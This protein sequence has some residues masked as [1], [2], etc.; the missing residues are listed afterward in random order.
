MKNILVISEMSILDNSARIARFVKIFGFA[1]FT[2]KSFQDDRVFVSRT[3]VLFLVG[4]LTLACLMFYFSLSYGLQCL[5]GK[6][7]M[8]YVAF[9]VMISS[10][11]VCIISII[12]NFFFRSKIWKLVLIINSIDLYFEKMN[13][14]TTPKQLKWKIFTGIA[15]FAAMI[16]IGI[17]NMAYFFNYH[18]KPMVLIHFMYLSFSFS[19]SMGWIILFH[20]CIYRRFFM[21]NK[22]IRYIQI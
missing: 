16:L 13:V 12:C 19:F 9:F 8:Q 7:L 5:I 6:S 20:I 4:N 1:T 3:D 11:V 22:I 17:F 15:F 14:D 18:K 21:M 2:I 10:S